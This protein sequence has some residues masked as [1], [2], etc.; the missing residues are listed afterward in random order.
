MTTIDDLA[1]RLA[2]AHQAGRHDVDPAPY[3]GI[4]RS[5]AFEVQQRVLAGMAS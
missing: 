2:A 4:G 1:Q 5:E 3:S